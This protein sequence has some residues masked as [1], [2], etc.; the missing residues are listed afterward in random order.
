MSQDC[1]TLEGFY[2]KRKYVEPLANGV[3]IFTAFIEN[4]PLDEFPA[5]SRTDQ[6]R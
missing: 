4:L 1:I 5:S 2:S 3:T 6:E